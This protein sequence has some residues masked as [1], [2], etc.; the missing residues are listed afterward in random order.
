MTIISF[1]SSDLLSLVVGLETTSLG[2]ALRSAALAPCVVSHARKEGNQRAGPTTR[3]R[4]Q[5]LAFLAN[6]TIIR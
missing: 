4:E 6:N 5:V 3:R 1:V 2:S